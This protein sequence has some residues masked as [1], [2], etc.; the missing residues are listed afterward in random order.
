MFI[1]TEQTPNPSTLKFIPGRVV[2]ERGTMDFATADAAASSPL[3]RRLF[4]VEGVERVFFGADFVSVT[5]TA[6]RDWQVLK[7]SILGGIMEHYTSGE[8][9]I[10]DA[11]AGEAAAEEDDEVV[12]QIKDLLDT[13]VRPAVA[14]DGGDIVFQD[15]RDGVVYLHMQGSCSGCPSSTATLKMGIENLLKHYVPEVIEV[16]AAQ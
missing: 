4:A 6:D 15:F 7:P 14:Q 2:M 11:A 13:R 1:Q 10:V 8:P 3:A 5:K 9:V 16:Q 12:A